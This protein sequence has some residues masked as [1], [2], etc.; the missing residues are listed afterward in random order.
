MA[1]INQK[2][3]GDCGY[4][5]TYKGKQIELYAQTTLQARNLAQECFGVKSKDAHK[6]TTSLVELKDGTPVIQD[7]S[8]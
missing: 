1:A 7:P 8:L 5:C 4:V 6:I 2:L 3:D